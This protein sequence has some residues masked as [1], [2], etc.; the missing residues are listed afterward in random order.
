MMMAVVIITGD[1]VV[2]VAMRM[3]KTTVCCCCVAM[4]MVI[5]TVCCCGVAMHGDNHGLR[6]LFVVGT[7]STII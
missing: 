4:S 6:C 1:V 7:R 5:T 3:A 2:C